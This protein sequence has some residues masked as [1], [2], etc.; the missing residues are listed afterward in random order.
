MLDTSELGCVVVDHPTVTLGLERHSTSVDYHHF[1]ES[2]HDELTF[3]HLPHVVLIH[4]YLRTISHDLA[5]QVKV[6]R[7]DLDLIVHVIFVMIQVFDLMP[8]LPLRLLFSVMHTEPL[9]E[10]WWERGLLLLFLHV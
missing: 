2:L 6:V 1:I 9:N 10:A 3:M 5:R 8:L 7:L 4:F